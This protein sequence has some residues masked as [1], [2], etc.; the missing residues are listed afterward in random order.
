ME[1]RNTIRKENERA[2]LVALITK[3]QDER[4]T[5]EYLYELEFLAENGRRNNSQTLHAK[6]RR[7]ELSHLCR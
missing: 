3:T 4:K 7:P 6:I 1:E 5:K 2:V